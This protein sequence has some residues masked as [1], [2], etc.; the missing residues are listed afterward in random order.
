[1]EVIRPFQNGFCTKDARQLRTSP[2]LISSL[3]ASHNRESIT[4]TF[5]TSTETT[6][7][8]LYDLHCVR[9]FRTENRPFPLRHRN[10]QEIPVAGF[11]AVNTDCQHRHFVRALPSPSLHV[12]S[13]PHSARERESRSSG[14]G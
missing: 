4:D 5:T 6:S 3:A 14:T 11:V 8:S 1:M 12:T 9:E 10:G 7:T 13:L 2:V